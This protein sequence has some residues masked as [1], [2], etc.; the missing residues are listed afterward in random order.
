MAGYITGVQNRKCKDCQFRG[1]L[2]ANGGG[3]LS[4]NGTGPYIQTS[5]F[6][7]NT[8]NNISGVHVDDGTNCLA[9]LCTDANNNGIADECED[10]IWTVDDDGP[11]DFDNIQSAIDA[12]S[13]GYEIIVMPGDVYKH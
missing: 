7:E 3:I 11:A 2:A 9:I 13:D 10:L 8:P 6:C 5:N 1:N 12:S 4:L